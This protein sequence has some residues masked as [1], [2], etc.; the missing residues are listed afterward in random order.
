M[1]TMAANDA[2]AEFWET[3]VP[4]WLA[5]EAASTTVAAPFGVAAMARLP[6]RPGQRVLDVGCGSGSTTIELARRVAPDGAALGVDIAPSMIDAAR[7]RGASEGIDHATFAVADAQVERFGDGTFD[8]AF[9][10]FGVMFFADLTAA[11][12]NIGRALAP[13]GRLA[14]ACWQP[15]FLNEWMLLPG[16]AAVT[17]TGALPPMPGPDE[18]GPFT[19][20]EPDR[21]RSILTAAGFVDIEVTPITDPVVLPADRVDAFAQRSLRIGAVRE[22]MRSADPETAT[23]IAEAVRVALHEKVTDGRLELA[24]AAFAVSGGRDA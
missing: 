16:S 4:D 1:P 17:V 2:Q 13:G 23:R 5:A 10:R 19:L 22:A 6:L 18:P 15:I 14:F 11:F 12:A 20:S 24:A 7:E 3:L 9:S 8:A 21:V